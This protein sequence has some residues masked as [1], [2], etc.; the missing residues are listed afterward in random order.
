MKISRVV[1]YAVDAGVGAWLFVKVESDDPDLYGWG[2]AGLR[3]KARPVRAEIE[4]LGDLIVGEDAF[5]TEHLWQLM[6][7]QHARG[8]LVTMAAIAGIDQALWDLKARALG[9]PLYEL[10]G[11]R[12]RDRVRVYEHVETRLRDFDRQKPES[13]AEAALQCVADGF[14]ALKIYPIPFKGRLEG[15]RAVRRAEEVVAAVRDAVGEQVDLMVDLHGRTFPALAVQ[16]AKALEPYELM[17][18]EEPCQ[19]ESVSALAEIARSTTIPIATGERLATRWEFARLLEA[20]A[21]SI[22]QPDVSHCGGIT[23][24][25]RIVEIAQLHFATVAPHNPYGPIA[26]MHHVHLATAMPNLLILEQLRDDVP[27]R[28]E[29][30]TSPLEFSDGYVRAP[31]R[32]GIGVDIVEDVCLAHPYVARPRDVPFS[33]EG[34]VLDD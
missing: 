34:A 6:Y 29:V 2:E 9:V 24:F 25:R 16:F 19:P 32:P 17:F 33:S 8:G 3:L 7:R 27:W 11:G 18:L 22:V 5:R 10:L 15:R 4:D 23:E 28:N 12:V 31:G 13:F 14:D 26:A 20:G 1:T 21:C 30:V